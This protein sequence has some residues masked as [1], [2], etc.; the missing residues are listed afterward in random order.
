MPEIISNSHPGLLVL[1]G[2]REEEGRAR[3]RQGQSGGSR[4]TRECHV[5]LRQRNVSWRRV[6][7]SNP[8][9]RQPSEV[10]S[11]VRAMFRTRT[12]RGGA[13]LFFRL[14]GIHLGLL[15]QQMRQPV[16][17]AGGRGGLGR[18]P[19]RRSRFTPS[20]VMLHPLLFP[21]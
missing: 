21:K 11:Q 1:S 14:A 17:A 10:E 9:R 5:L 18:S 7:R 4:G 8:H 3:V 19:I 12:G 2:P 6:R 20:G 16:G 15:D 13:G